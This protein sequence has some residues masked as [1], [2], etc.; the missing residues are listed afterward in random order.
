M[1]D[2]WRHIDSRIGRKLSHLL[3]SQSVERSPCG[4]FGGLFRSYSS[5]D[6]LGNLNKNNLA[7]FNLWNLFLEL[8]KR[9]K[10]E[11]VS[12]YNHGQYIRFAYNGE[13]RCFFR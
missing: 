12:K 7:A 3:G 9:K 5:N 8:K 11:T 4:L 10:H 1:V 13:S 6:A 2:S